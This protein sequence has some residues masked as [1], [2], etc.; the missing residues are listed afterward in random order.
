[1]TKQLNLFPVKGE[2][3][4]K[5]S[6]KQIMLVKVVQYKFCAMGFGRYC[7]IHEED[8]PCNGMVVRTQGAILLGPSGNAQGGHK[9]FTLTTGKVVI[10]W[11][12]TEL[13]TSVAIIERVHLLAKGMPALPNFTVHAGHVIGDVK[14]V[15]LHNI[16][17]EDVETLI[18]NGNLPGVHT[19]EADDKIPGMDAVQEQDVDVDLDFAPAN[20]GNFEPPLVDIPP[21]VNDATVVSKV[22]TDGGARRSTRICTQ[23]KPQYI[24]AF[25]GKMYSFATTVLDTKMLDNVAYGYNQ[26]VAF[27]FMQQLLVKSALREWGD[28]VRA[29]GEKE[30]TKYIGEIRSSQGKCWSLLW[31]NELKFSRV[32]CSLG[33]SGQGRPRLEWL[34][35]EIRSGVM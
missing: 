7:Q 14:D 3:S 8:Q 15:Y 16:E 28:N 10:C 22:P 4:S 34:Q 19:A 12:W 35:V 1:V 21:P 30:V 20:D 23:P 24:P 33:R 25:S 17:D 32:T 2:L 31:S 13:P 5:L 26:S 11:A 6:P 27:S 18:D 29:A 9:F